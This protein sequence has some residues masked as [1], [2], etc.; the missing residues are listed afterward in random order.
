MNFI[1]SLIYENDHI[2]F[3]KFLLKILRFFKN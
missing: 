3:I 1:N 2:N